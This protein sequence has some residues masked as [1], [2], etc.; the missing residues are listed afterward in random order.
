MV[1]Q[2]DVPFSYSEE[3][4]RVTLASIGDA[5]IVTDTK[6]AI[7]FMN[8]VAES[9]T[10][11]TEKEAQHQAVETV[12]PILDEKSRANIANPV[13]QILQTGT[14]DEVANHPVLLARNGVEVAIDHSVAPIR[15]AQGKIIGVVLVFRDITERKR[16][17][18]TQHQLAAIFATSDDAIISKTLDSRITS[19]NQAAE[20]MFGYRADEVIGQPITLLIP[21][22]RLA[23][24]EMILTRLKQGDHVDHYETVRRTKDGRLLDISLSI[25]PIQDGEG[26]IVGAAK[27]ARDITA[28][29]R[30][31][32]SLQK[33]EE[34][35]RLSHQ[36]TGVGDWEWISSTNEVF[37]S[38]EYRQIY[39]LDPKEPASFEK[40]MEVVLPEDR[41]AITQAI[42]HA[43]ATGEEYRSEHRIHHPNKG[44][45]WIQAM[46]KTVSDESQSSKRMLGIVMDVTA[47]KQ[48]EQEL[49]ESAER[50]SLALEAAELGDWSW[51]AATD[52]VTLSTRAATILGV[53]KTNILWSELRGL[54]H[55]ED[56]A[57]ASQVVAQALAAN[58]RFNI[59]YR[60]RQNE[61]DWRGVAAKGQAI[62]NDAKQLKFIRGVVQDITERKL[63]DTRLEE[64]R[65]ALEIINQAGQMLSAELDLQKLVQRLTDAATEITGA[66]F[67]S[68]FYNVL[69]ERG[70]SYMLYT[71]SGV[72]RDHF[73]HFPMPRAT[74][75]FG[76][77]F[78]GEGVIRIDNVKHDS[79]YG[80]NSPYFG[81]PEGH[82]PVTSYLAVP[83]VSRSGEVLGGLFFGHAEASIFTAR[84]ERI[85]AG[86]AGQA[87]IAMDNARLYEATRKAQIEAENAN[88]LKDEFLATVSHELRTPLNAI[89]GWA[90][91]LRM[92]RLKEESR[93]RAIGIIEK[94][95][96][97]QGQII[98]DILDV[99]RIITGQLRLEVSPVEIAQVVE[100]AVESVRPTADA[101]GV[102]LQSV[103][104]TKTNL[105]AGDAHR[106]QQVCWNLLSN[107][108]KFTPKGGRVQVTLARIDSHVEI[109]V[110]DTGQGIAPEF[111]PHVFERFRQADSSTTRT[112]GGLGLGLAI[113]RHLTELHGGTVSA[114]SAGLGQGA[115]F[116][117]FLPLAILREGGSLLAE[118]QVPR[119]Q[120]AI[121]GPMPSEMEQELTD[122][123]VLVVDDEVDAREL[124][125]TVL[126]QCG[127][128]VYAVDSVRSAMETLRHWRPDV[129]V[130]D[131]GMP[132]EDGYELIRQV[133]AMTHKEGGSIPA[134]AL[135][136]Y[137]RSEDRL[138]ALKAGFQMHVA[139]PVEPV[140]LVAV[141]ASLAGKTGSAKDVS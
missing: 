22:E 66:Q 60:V 10:G 53:Q 18:A 102:R 81:M 14:V 130:S 71:L 92:G 103:L 98:E 42:T 118:Q 135:T 35:L 32:S 37:W 84:H 21:P 104:D 11:W 75:L 72:S 8:A 56:H 111:L 121:E 3:R 78:R 94:S 95:A 47:Q 33:N 139:K 34:R 38:P 70:A 67:G 91:M 86:L 55:E 83:V 128:E 109:T 107:A 115:T 137:A 26:N 40:G 105:V 43:L 138:R 13:S 88:R 108:I 82:L 1:V 61:K 52:E 119:F 51:E 127:A 64:E 17:E 7:T 114:T 59:E 140:E 79:R 113:V 134:T 90:R 112:Y 110:S 77:T 100:E 97:A 141:V 23:E 124:L 39:G 30:L 48:V 69:D 9:L 76:P 129:L 89:L 68:F 74:D 20:R 85:V 6:G 19:W 120:Q 131:I 5:V 96:V 63:A 44:L 28:S 57:R 27:I 126:E 58:A 123:R 62:Y 132:G 80:K 136:A 46:G 4:W 45:R 41:E 24:E 25:S 93:T 133:R 49:R 31:E 36:V 2:S 87:A 50:L 12:F 106:L 125:Q 65:E 29:K 117:V 116:R 99:S 122:V 54:L 73:A 15:D 16:A 101:K